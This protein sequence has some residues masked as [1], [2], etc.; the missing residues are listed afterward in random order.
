MFGIGILGLRVCASDL[1]GQ[2]CS[3][4]GVLRLPTEAASPRQGGDSTEQGG[5]QARGATR[6]SST[7]TS[8]LRRIVIRAE[9]LD[10]GIKA[11][12]SAAAVEPEP[13]PEGQPN[14]RSATA[15]AARGDLLREAGS[16]RT[17]RAGIETQHGGEQVPV[18]RSRPSTSVATI[19][20]QVG[21]QL[22]ETGP[23]FCGGA[24]ESLGQ[25]PLWGLA[26]EAGQPI[27]STLRGTCSA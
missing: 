6:R 27:G 23:A 3:G 10:N 12:R 16:E 1:R 14:A 24:M 21:G 26:Q 4:R 19:S 2:R 15:D 25:H 22:S 8:S 13:V 18:G 9:L 11:S 7:G 5:A 20:E 17:N